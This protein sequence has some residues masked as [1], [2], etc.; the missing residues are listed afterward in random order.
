MK[1]LPLGSAAQSIP[2]IGKRYAADHNPTYFIFLFGF[3]DNFVRETRKGSFQF[4]GNE[5]R[6]TKVRTVRYAGDEVREHIRSRL[7]RGRV[8]DNFLVKVIIIIITRRL[9][10]IYA[11]RATIF[12][13]IRCPNN[14]PF[15]FS[16]VRTVSTTRTRRV[17][18][19]NCV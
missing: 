5:F 13:I 4:L 12:R 17:Y 11:L 18:R 2:A 19:S 8:V 10:S 1:T 7:R 9:S 6:V 3:H 16:C 14:S 15:V